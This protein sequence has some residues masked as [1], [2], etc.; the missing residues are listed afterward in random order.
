MKQVILSFKNIHFLDGRGLG[1]WVRKMKVFG[2]I[3]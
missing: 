1:E 3:N 2:S